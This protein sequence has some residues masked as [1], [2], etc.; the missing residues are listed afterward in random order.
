MITYDYTLTRDLFSEKETHRPHPELSGQ[1]KNVIIVEGPNGK[2]KSLLMNIIAMAA[3]G[4]ENKSV[5]ASLRDDMAEYLR[6]DTTKLDFEL[7][8]QDPVSRK[9][10]R[11]RHSGT[12]GTKIVISE[13]VDEGRTFRELSLSEFNDKYN[14]VYDIPE[15]PRKRIMGIIT[16]ARIIQDDCKVSIKKAQNL[17]QDMLDDIQDHTIDKVQLYQFKKEIE[18]FDGRDAKVTADIEKLKSQSE[19]LMKYYH[20]QNLRNLRDSRKRAEADYDSVKKQEEAKE[21]QPEE[22]MGRYN[23]KVS[24]VRKELFRISSLIDGAEADIYTLGIPEAIDSYRRLKDWNEE[25]I[26]RNKSVDPSFYKAIQ[27]ILGCLNNYVES[28]DTEAVRLLESLINE[29]E[30]YKGKNIALEGLGTVDEIIRILEAQYDEKSIAK[31]PKINLDKLKSN[32]NGI[33]KAIEAVSYKVADLEDPPKLP[34]EKKYRDQDK[35]DRYER[36]VQDAKYAEKVG[37]RDAE[38]YGVSFDNADTIVGRTD[39]NLV[40]KYDKMDIKRIFADAADLERSY[41]N[42]KNSYEEHRKSIERKRIRV[43]EWESNVESKYA[44]H[45][46]AIETI[47][48]E[49][50]KIT[51]RLEE[52][53]KRF[54]AVETSSY[55]GFS[56]ADPLFPVLWRYLGRRLKTVRYNDKEYQVESVNAMKQLVVTESVQIPISSF[57]TGLNQRNYL[58]TKLTTEDK[59]PMIV[60]FDEIGIMDPE[61]QREL[62]DRMIKLQSEGKLMV[63]M[64][65]RPAPKIGVI[66]HGQ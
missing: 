28:S 37:Y 31:K 56:E 43:E 57:S 41:N 44:C 15:N 19:I 53:S 39:R 59:R 10:L 14:L 9:I 48:D 58:I 11:A 50:Y 32:L 12:D 36:R 22:I 21:T 26:I 30:K 16:N 3:Y 61:I 7:E 64:L 29:L 40:S 17:V 65:N 52:M 60:L 46:D 5:P 18:D 13:S 24:A 66:N 63:G 8:I 25:K 35:I 34:A 38:K 6:G 62:V 51:K 42:Q 47:S 1:L 33:G 27:K 45:E 20:A 55:Q 49:L 2:G 54:R 23:Q 4:Y